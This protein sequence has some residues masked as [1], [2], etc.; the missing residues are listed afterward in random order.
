MPPEWALSI[1][2]QILKRK[3]DVINCCCYRAVKRLDHGMK[4]V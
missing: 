2:V 1:V 3:V 4:V